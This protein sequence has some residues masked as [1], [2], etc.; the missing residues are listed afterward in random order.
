MEE[1]PAEAACHLNAAQ[2][3]V[4]GNSHE[5]ETLRSYHVASVSAEEAALLQ[6]RKSFWFLQIRSESLCAAETNTS[7]E[8]PDSTKCL[9]Q[10]SRSENILRMSHAKQLHKHM[11]MKR[12]PHLWLDHS[13]ITTKN[14]DKLIPAQRAPLANR[15][16]HPLKTFIAMV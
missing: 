6:F 1:I 8:I 4:H 13:K 7:D 5:H 9:L 15:V 14:M 12:L 10:H 2:Q 3:S 11:D 16:P